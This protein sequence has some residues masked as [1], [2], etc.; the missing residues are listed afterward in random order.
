MVP[1][2]AT[3]FPTAITVV[4]IAWA[5]VTSNIAEASVTT[6]T[7]SIMVSPTR[8]VVPTDPVHCRDALN[9]SEITINPVSTKVN[10]VF[11]AGLQILMYAG[12][13]TVET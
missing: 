8:V 5:G 9:L 7:W 4:V 6:G 3:V 12:N 11:E 1:E 13:Q 10:N 2:P